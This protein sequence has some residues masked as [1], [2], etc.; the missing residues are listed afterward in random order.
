[1]L[2]SL[3]LHNKVAEAWVENR[4]VESATMYNTIAMI[5]EEGE[6]VEVGKDMVL[7]MKE[8]Q[9]DINHE[10]R[11]FRNELVYKIWTALY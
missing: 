7:V 11:M 9:E 3:L 10:D 2:A 4:E 8:N 6:N 5:V 1:V